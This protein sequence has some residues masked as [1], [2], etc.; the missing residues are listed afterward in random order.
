MAKAHGSVR[1]GPISLFTLI[2]VL[3][4]AVMAVLSVSTAQAGFAITQRQ[5]AMTTSTYENEVAA[6]EFIAHVDAAL[7]GVRDNGG[8]ASDAKK[9]I[10]PVLAQYAENNAKVEGSTV[11]ATFVAQGN[12]TLSV[13]LAI[14]N[15][16]TYSVVSWK[17]TTL[18]EQSQSEI[19]WQGVIGS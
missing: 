14:N 17:A 1:I 11:T 12:R 8:D 7:A 6:Q 3:C 19:L 13:E 16:A 10:E 9:A 4:L 2:V 5:A 18:W 15:D